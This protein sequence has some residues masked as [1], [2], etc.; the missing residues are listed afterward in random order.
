MSTRHPTQKTFLRD[1]ATHQ[2][3]IIKD[4]GLYR[5]IRLK[6]PDST[7]YYYDLITW[8]GYLSMTGDMGCY[9]FQRNRDMFEFFRPDSYA[10]NRVKSGLY[11]NPCYWGEK[12]EAVNAQDGA[13]KKYCPATFTKSVKEYF[14]RHGK[15]SF[16]SELFREIKSQVLNS[17][18]DEYEAVTAVREFE[19]EGFEFVDFWEYGITDYTYHYI[20]A[21]YAIVWGIQQYDA[22]TTKAEIAA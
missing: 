21:C 18:D 14:L 1:V 13:I 15:K 12:L 10:L 2:I 17:A 6:R 7:S 22:A 19:H 8:P 16:N 11:I 5:H 20:W 4:D 3:T 9:V